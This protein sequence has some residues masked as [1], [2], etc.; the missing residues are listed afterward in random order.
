MHSQTGHPSDASGW[1]A[2][3]RAWSMV[4]TVAAIE[5]DSIVRRTLR[6]A[7]AAPQ[8]ARAAAQVAEPSVDTPAVRRFRAKF[9]AGPH[10]RAVQGA[11]L[12]LELAEP[13]TFRE[14]RRVA[15]PSGASTPDAELALAEAWEQFRHD[16]YR[17]MN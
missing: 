17:A 10:D 3:R 12:L 15:F 7:R 11:E 9:M 6:D 5:S 13:A 8:P 14:A 1:Q 4:R 2:G 16:R